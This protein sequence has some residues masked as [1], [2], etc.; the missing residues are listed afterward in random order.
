VLHI[1]GA[2]VGPRNCANPRR[3]RE[4]AME[5]KP[6]AHT[7]LGRVPWSADLTLAEEHSHYTVGNM[8]QL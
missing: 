5:T 6:K 2:S 4:Q 8:S 1:K 3:T 7:R